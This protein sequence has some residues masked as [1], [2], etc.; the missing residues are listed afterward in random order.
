M[1]RFVR[2]VHNRLTSVEL[3][4]DSGLVDQ[5]AEPA[6]ETRRSARRMVP[7]GGFGLA[8]LICLVILV[9]VRTRT[10]STPSTPTPAVTSVS[11]PTPAVTVINGATVLDEPW[12]ILN[13]ETE[14]VDDDYKACD[15]AKG[16]CQDDRILRK[17]LR[18][19]GLA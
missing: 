19:L 9:V 4:E 18:Q 1:F 12:M 17:V 7:T 8:L 13:N 16:E 3:T 15:F 6:N 11:T 2:R 10:A 14:T 5:N